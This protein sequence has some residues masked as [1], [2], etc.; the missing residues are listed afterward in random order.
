MKGTL[1]YI[2]LF[3]ALLCLLIIIIKAQ[4]SSIETINIG[5]YLDPEEGGK[6]DIGDDDQVHLIEET[7]GHQDHEDQVHD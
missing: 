4:S 1:V 5:T 6:D 3:I 7:A 2:L